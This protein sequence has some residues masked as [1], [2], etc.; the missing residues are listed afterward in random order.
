MELNFLTTH[1]I[2]DCAVTRRTVRSAGVPVEVKARTVAWW[3]EGERGADMELAENSTCWAST[4]ALVRG[5][6]VFDVG[7]FIGDRDAIGRNGNVGGCRTAGEI[8]AVVHV[9]GQFRGR[10]VKVWSGC[11]NMHPG[12]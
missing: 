11:G 12:G 9:H 1:A 10:K 6:Y 2:S 3:P 8:T 7:E 5:H 4:L